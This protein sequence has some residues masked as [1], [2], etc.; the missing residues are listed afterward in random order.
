[1]NSENK[2]SLPIMVFGMFIML[3]LLC[4]DKYLGITEYFY[5][6]III[7]VCLLVYYTKNIIIFKLEH[8][9]ILFLIFYLIMN[10][11]RYEY[12]LNSGVYLSYIIFLVMFLLLTSR[13]INKKEIRF[14]IN[15]YIVSGLIISAIIIIMKQEFNGWSGTYRYTVKFMNGV[16]IDPNYIGAFINIPAIF[17]FNRVFISKQR[18]YKHI[19]IIQTLVMT[20]AIFSTGSRGSMLGLMVGFSIVFS[21]NIKF[22]IKSLIC[23]IGIMIILAIVLYNVI[24]EETIKRMFFDSYYDASNISRL[25]NWRLGIEA[26]CKKP[27]WGYGFIDTNVI[28]SRN[29]EYSAAIHNTYLA[30]LNQFGIIGSFP[31]LVIILKIAKQLTKKEMRS[32]LGV[33]ASVI[34]TSILVEQNV[35]IIF[36]CALITLYLIKNYKEY[37]MMENILDVL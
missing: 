18:I 15:S 36:W 7:I 30:F 24:P 29:F 11:T 10:L 8:Y 4:N 33:L 13:K 22:K 32:L 31:I 23:S 17:V 28:L 25:T 27:F 14:L 3:I 19:N 20:F 5:F 21:C 34:L 9:C 35:S 37:N 26:L 16:Y 6:P 12:A 1:M 2:V